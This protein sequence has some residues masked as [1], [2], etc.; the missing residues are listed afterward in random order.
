MLPTVPALIAAAA[1]TCAGA[2]VIG[3]AACRLCGSRTWTFAAAPVGLALLLL[4]SVAAIHAPGHTTTVGVVLI[5]LALASVAW[6][7]ARPMPG[8]RLSDIAAVAPVVFLA[9]MPFLAS[10]RAG[11]LGVSFDNDMATHLRW[12]EAIVSK[13]VA[14]VSGLDPTYPVGPHALTAVLAHGLGTRVDYAFA[15]VTMAVPILTAWTALMG[16]RRA[17]WLAKALVVTVV[18]IS[19]LLA[20]YYAQGSFKELMQAMFV[21]GF[22]LVLE[23]MRAGRIVGMLRW[24][25]AA[26]IVGGSLS[27]YSV[28][29]LPWFLAIL[30]ISA[31]VLGA[32]WALR[33]GRV[34]SGLIAARPALAS[35]VIACGV[36]LVLLIPQLPR[37]VKFYESNIGTGGGTGIPTS[38]LGNLAGPL[39]FWK[40]FGMWDEPD[41]R[42]PAIDPL[43]VGALA[44]CALVA[45]LVG[46]GWWIRRKGP[47]VPIATAAA[48]AIW[49]YSDRYQSPYV[50]A[51]ALVVAAPLIL[52]VTSRWVV[53]LGPRE[54]WLSSTGVLRI[55]VAALFGW[56]AITSSVKTLRAAFVDPTAH[57]SDLQSLRPVVGGS[58]TLFLGTDDFIGWE[59]AGTPV[60][61]PYLG[62]LHFALNPQKAWQPGQPL[63]FDDI[64]AEVLD[65]YQFVI[66]PRDPAASQ[67]PSNMR[68]VRVS[69]YYEV[70]S[71]V[72]PT[73]H[74]L[75]LREGSEPGAVLNC[76]KPYGR[77]IARI[78]G[79]AALREPEA[80]VG[81]PPLGPGSRV[82]V[83]M[84]LHAGRW[85]LSAPYTSPNP[86]AVD[87]PGLH[88]V[89]P[90]NLDRPGNRWPVGEITIAATGPTTFTFTVQDRSLAGPLP[91]YVNALEA[92]PVAPERV[93]PLSQACGKYVDWYQPG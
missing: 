78:K 84:D 65:R 64:P 31:I 19:F 27:C 36:V 6:L 1:L 23:E 8:L 58:H 62:Y 30:G 18:S 12:A 39:E 69:R 67:P 57:I 75:T 53:T 76:A 72:G 87:A 50:A 5:L 86:I 59:L 17:G 33:A 82:R 38:S 55:A 63:D 93:V 68:L 4:I 80:V 56:A 42:L 43:L 37:L 79:I 41:Y 49:I 70:W 73:P 11:T 25:P 85:R 52:L 51:K 44:G 15:G 14:G 48:T 88:A 60:D 7:V 83:R 9:L 22:A 29:G 45:A 13:T 91:T 81:V 26:L 34:R 10:G 61:Q 16:L 54:S 74:R 90:A 77:A 66:G 28:G 21:L 47:F 35:M 71:R 24:I 2:L 32:G 46:L 92:T 3:Q 20:G 89:L 40:V